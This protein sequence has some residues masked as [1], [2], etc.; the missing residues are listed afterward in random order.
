VNGEHDLRFGVFGRP[1]AKGSKRAITLRNSRHVA[2][3]DSNRNAAPWA[4]H[5]SHA[6]AIAQGSQ[7][8]I[9]GPVT[10]DMTFHFA[11]PRAHFRTGRNA[12]ELRSTAPAH[13]TTMPDIDKLARCALDALT[14][15]VFKDDG[16]VCELT[17][18]KRYG[19]PERLEVVLHDLSDR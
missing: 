10:V 9:R 14:G 16:Q 17:L 5:V 12:A 11:R 13:M 6:A 19:E 18:R 8:L 4:A 1:Q 15:V 2:V 3:V 7:P